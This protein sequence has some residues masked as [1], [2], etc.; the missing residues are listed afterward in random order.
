MK[1]L[2]ALQC[3]FS[4]RSAHFLPDC[5]GLFSVKDV[6]DLILF[7]TLCKITHVAQSPSAVVEIRKYAKN[8]F[9]VLPPSVVMSQKTFRC[10]PSL[11]G[12]IQ[13]SPFTLH[14]PLSRMSLQDFDAKVK[15]T[16]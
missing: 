3:K 15:I 4:V 10:F 2:G 11:A 12:S 6:T 8:I 16:C 14:T 13:Y 9:V 7:W 1:N 5:R